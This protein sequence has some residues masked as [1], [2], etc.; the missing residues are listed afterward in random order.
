MSTQERPAAKQAADHPQS[1]VRDAFVRGLESCPGVYGA[2]EFGATATGKARPNDY[3]IRVVADSEFVVPKVV[4]ERV[5]AVTSGVKMTYSIPMDIEVCDKAVPQSM[6]SFLGPTF[7]EHIR[8]YGKPIFGAD[9]RPLHT[10]SFYDFAGVLTPMQLEGAQY[11]ARNL[12]ER[13]REAPLLYVS[14]QMDRSAFERTITHC[15]K[16]TTFVY[17]AMLLQGRHVPYSGKSDIL[18][19]FREMHGEA[20]SEELKEFQRR[21]EC[22]EEFKDDEKIGMFW[23]ALNFRERLVKKLS[24]DKDIAKLHEDL[25][26]R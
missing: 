20:L 26:R 10:S 19:A 22:L 14:R 25:L 24:E 12:S 1:A 8:M 17:N 21:R 16:L 6:F 18:D 23:N 7:R 9:V 11:L 13:R 3:D 15:A 5:S 2:V 4:Y